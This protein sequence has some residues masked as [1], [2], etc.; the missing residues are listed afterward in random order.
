MNSAGEITTVE[1]QACVTK[2]NLV[3]KNEPASSQTSKNQHQQPIS[4]EVRGMQTI[5]T[6]HIVVKIVA[7]KRLAGN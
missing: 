1:S 7:Q 5:F 3:G 2:T 4:K 6:G